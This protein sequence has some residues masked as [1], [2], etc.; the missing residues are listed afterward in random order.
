MIQT[1]DFECKECGEVIFNMPKINVQRHMLKH[2]IDQL[3]DVS[4]FRI[5]HKDYYVDYIGQAISK[6]QKGTMP[7]DW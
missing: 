5:M 2:K 1:I 6:I 4:V 3:D 7:K